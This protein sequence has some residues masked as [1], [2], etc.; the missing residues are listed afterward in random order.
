MGHHNTVQEPPLTLAAN[1]EIDLGSSSGS[2]DGLIISERPKMF[3]FSAHN[4]AGLKR[5]ITQYTNCF[6]TG[7]VNLRKK[8]FL[9]NLAYTLAARRT[10]LRW[11]SFLLANSAEDLIAL[12]TRMSLPLPAIDNATLG[13]IFTGQGAQWAGMGHGLSCF[14]VFQRSLQ[15]AEDY[16]RNIGCPWLLRGKL[17]IYSK[18][19]ILTKNRGAF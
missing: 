2:L 4:E 19:I 14:E 7:I 3:V 17:L 18:R 8:D 16:L 6:Q 5:M 12:S 1:V 11:K 15:D 13:F 9:T 10:P